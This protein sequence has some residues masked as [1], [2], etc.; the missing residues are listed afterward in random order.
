ME[1]RSAG[2]QLRGVLCSWEGTEPPA[3][4]TAKR[5]TDVQLEI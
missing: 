5:E 2:S 1:P 3:M 4:V